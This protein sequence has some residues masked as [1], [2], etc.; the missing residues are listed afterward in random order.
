M[1]K[2]IVL[3]ACEIAKLAC[4]SLRFGHES[5]QSNENNMTNL[6]VVTDLV[7]RLEDKISIDPV[8]K[9]FVEIAISE[10]TKK[11]EKY[12]PEKIV[13]AFG[14]SSI[15]GYFACIAEECSEIVA[16]S[17]TSNTEMLREIGDLLSVHRRL[18]EIVETEKQ[19]NVAVLSW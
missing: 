14:S 3:L 11:L 10:K 8:M 2:D 4:K 7:C 5:R 16:A 1:H 17:M 19:H 18:K 15:G 9:N 6:E 12:G 13:P